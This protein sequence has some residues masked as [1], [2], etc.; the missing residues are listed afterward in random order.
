MAF[1]IIGVV[2]ALLI[3]VAVIAHKKNQ[4]RIAAL[5]SLALSKQWQYFPGDPFNLSARWGFHPFGRGYARQAS[6]VIT[7]QV[8]PYAM[9]AFDYQYKEDS[10]DSK[11]NRTTHTYPFGVCALAMPCALPEL[12][13]APEGVL[14]RIGN[15]LGMDDIELES[16]EFNRRYRVRCPDRKLA[17]DVLTPRTMETLLQAGGFNARFAGTDAVCATSGRLRAADLLNHTAA[18]AALIDGIPTF[19]WKDYGLAERPAG[20]PPTASPGSM[21]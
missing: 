4:E 9:V 13:L 8:G 12:H 5:Q 11:G 1:L 20:S 16:E 18:M 6:N 15:A 14:T 10:T 21:Q 3:T 19:V 17:T 7:G 2:A